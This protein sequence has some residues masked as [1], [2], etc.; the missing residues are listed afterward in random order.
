MMGLW[1]RE[2]ESFSEYLE[3]MDYVQMMTA[4]IFFLY[5]RF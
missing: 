5:G 1:K 4:W 3:M 2:R